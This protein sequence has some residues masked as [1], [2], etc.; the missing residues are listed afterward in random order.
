MESTSERKFRRIRKKFL[1]EDEKKSHWRFG[2]PIIIIMLLVPFMVGDYFLGVII[3]LLFLSIV[4]VGY[5]LLMGYCGQISFGQTAFVGIGAY[6]AAYAA[7]IWGWPFAMAL[8]FAGLAAAL[9]GLL[10]AIPSLRLGHLYLAVATMGFA[11]I[12][13]EAVDQL[14]SITGGAGGVSVVPAKLFGYSFETDVS[15]YY[16]TLFFAVLLVVLAKNIAHSAIGRSFIA[17]RDSEEA[18]EANG[19]SL[20]RTKVLAF[21]VSTFYAG[22]AG[23]LSA[24]Y[25]RFISPENF[26]FAHSIEYVVMVIVGG[27]ASIYGAVIGA[28]IIGYLPHFTVFLKDTVPPF[29]KSV[30]PFFPGVAGSAENILGNPDFRLLLYGAIMLFF[31][32]YEPSGVYGIWLR[33]KNYWKTFPFNR[34][35]V[36]FKGRRTLLYRSY[37]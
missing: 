28:F 19:I 5:N 35:K 12:V 2:I 34:K 27:M 23:G 22:I 10:V 25:L 4:C 30:V 6:A 16:L 8:I 7:N 13:E 15:F 33:F 9:I 17:V 3:G 32:V 26:T 31:M 1:K 14:E 11:F 18:A 37:R 24:F 29:L 21:A 36:K 20:T